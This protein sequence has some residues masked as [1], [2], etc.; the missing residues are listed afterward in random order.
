[1][2][3]IV[4]K[5]FNIVEPDVAVF[6]KKDYQQWRVIC[7]M[8]R[9]LDFDIEIVGVA[10]GREA[11]GLAMSSRNAL[12]TPENRQKAVCISQA[13]T[14]RCYFVQCTKCCHS[15]PLERLNVI[16]CDPHLHGEHDVVCF[17]MIN[18]GKLSEP[19]YFRYVHD[20][21]I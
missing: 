20:Q 21:Q 3:Q 16:E 7:R 17:V 19:C 15:C 2:L 11:D 10:T 18:L 9:D 8:V 1:M 12:L 5:L 6:G 4:A 13:L 14:V